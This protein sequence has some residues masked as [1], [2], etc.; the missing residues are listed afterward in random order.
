MKRIVIWGASG[1]AIVLDEF[2]ADIGFKLVALFDNQD[3]PSPI[4]GVSVYRGFDGFRSWHAGFDQGVC[5]FA[6]AV[7]GW[8]GAVRLSIADRLSDRGL[9]STNLVHPSSTVARN[10]SLGEG[11]QI[12]MNSGLGARVRIGDYCIINTSASV[13][14]ECVLGDG[15][16]VG[17][18]ATLAGLV[19]VGDR[20]FIGAGATILPRVQIGQ[21]VIVGAG[22]VVTRD[23]PDRAIAYGIPA[24]IKN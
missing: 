18:G 16:H 2:L 24:K 5:Y 4:E 8:D 23:L 3:V 12:L 22:A 17:P 19:N 14:H 9:L 1:Q 20:S 15:V 11:C 13:D 7:G 6:I 21:D 10:V